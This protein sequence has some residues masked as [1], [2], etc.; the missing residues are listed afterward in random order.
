[1]LCPGVGPQYKRHGATA[2]GPAEGTEVLQ[3]L[4][5]L[6]AQRCR[7]SAEPWQLPLP[8]GQHCW[9]GDAVVRCGQ[10]AHQSILFPITLDALVYFKP[11]LLYVG[12]LSFDPLG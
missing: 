12:H 10:A 7:P 9:A 2:G 8:L 1:M 4:E 6:R 5:P 3:G 11:I